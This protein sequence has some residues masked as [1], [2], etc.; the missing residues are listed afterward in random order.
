MSS[1]S[2]PLQMLMWSAI[3]EMK[4]DPKDYLQVFDLK[5]EKGKQMVIH[6]QE[7]PEYRNIFWVE[8]EEI[9]RAKVFVIDDGEHSTMLLAEE[10]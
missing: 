1:I 7:Q 2:V 10:Y 6:K 9:C 5:E 4:T 3:D 8:S